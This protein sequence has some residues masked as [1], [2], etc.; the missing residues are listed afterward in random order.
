MRLRCNTVLKRYLD[1]I[2]VGV[3]AL[4]LSGIF[5]AVMFSPLHAQQPPATGGCLIINGA[6]GAATNNC[7][8][9]LQ[10]Y[11]V[12]ALPTCNASRLGMQAYV[13]DAL[14]PTYN[15]AL[16]GGSTAKVP[17]FCNGTAWTSH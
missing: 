17:V 7:A 13:T 9:I 4:A 11:L 16:T 12:A 6:T 5:A 10:G 14:T 8:F 2:I 3:A 15:G 1:A